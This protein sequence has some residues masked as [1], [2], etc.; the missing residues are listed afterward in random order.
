MGDECSLTQGL[1]LFG[2][3]QLGRSLSRSER[4]N[5]M[6]ESA[7][8][9]A[10]YGMLGVLWV[11]TLVLRVRIAYIIASPRGGGASS[12]W[13]SSHASSLAMCL[14]TLLVVGAIWNFTGSNFLLLV[15]SPRLG[16]WGQFGAII[17]SLLLLTIECYFTWSGLDTI[18]EGIGQLIVASH[19][20][21]SPDRQFGMEA[22]RRGMIPLLAACV[23]V[24]CGWLFAA[25]LLPQWI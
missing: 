12:R 25:W 3:H 5:G 6:G 2:S 8:L 21:R 15:S 16:L 1:S 19:G 4:E 11:V 24:V 22:I 13:I 10:F 18:C 7:P 9:A 20:R 17:A 23:C 14:S